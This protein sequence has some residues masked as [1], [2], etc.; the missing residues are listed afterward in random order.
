MRLGIGTTPNLIDIV[1]GGRGGLILFPPKN[2]IIIYYISNMKTIKI[3]EEQHDR[4]RIYAF[5][6]K[7]TIQESIDM[8]IDRFFDVKVELCNS[9]IVEKGNSVLDHLDCTDKEAQDLIDPSI[10]KKF[11]I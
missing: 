6:N 4:L 3:T 2:K 10:L 8:A 9:V 7:L 5:N 11:N 1:Y